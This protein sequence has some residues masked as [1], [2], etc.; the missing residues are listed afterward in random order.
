MPLRDTKDMKLIEVNEPRAPM[1][2]ER[3]HN[4]PGVFDLRNQGDG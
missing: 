3:F 4:G 1:D 2:E